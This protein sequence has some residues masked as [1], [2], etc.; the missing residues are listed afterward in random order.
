MAKLGSVEKVAAYKIR[1]FSLL[2][3]FRKSR[4]MIKSWKEE[5]KIYLKSRFKSNLKKIK[6]GFNCSLKPQLNRD[7]I[8]V[9][10]E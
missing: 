8:P 3:L 2:M 4:N 7:K 6:L 1:L 5:E 9:K 10:L